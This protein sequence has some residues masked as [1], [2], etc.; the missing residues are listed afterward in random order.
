MAPK[1]RLY[2]STDDVMISG[3]CGGVAEYF[4]VD[5]TIVRV[6]WVFLTIAGMGAGLLLYIIM[7]IIV[8]V[9]PIKSKK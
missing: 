6:L 2:R 9:K 1:K 5:P 3:V 8:P 4:D 7:A